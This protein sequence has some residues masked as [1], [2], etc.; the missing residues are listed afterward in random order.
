MR[1]ERVSQWWPDDGRT[2]NCDLISGSLMLVGP[3]LVRWI[4][5]IVCMVTCWSG[6]LMLVGPG[7]VR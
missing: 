4:V 1:Q 6:S 7:L 2:H 3:G 5:I